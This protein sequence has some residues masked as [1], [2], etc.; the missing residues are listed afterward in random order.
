MTLA[1]VSTRQPTVRSLSRWLGTLDRTV[2]AGPGEC[3]VRCGQPRLHKSVGR[4]QEARVI[5]GSGSH[6]FAE[7][8]SLAA[9]CRGRRPLSQAIRRAQ[10]FWRDYLEEK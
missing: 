4:F 9:P 3:A 6:Y 7:V 5:F 10:D 2:R 1:F 8:A